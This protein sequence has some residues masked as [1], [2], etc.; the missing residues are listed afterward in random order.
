MVVI[1]AFALIVWL[2]WPNKPA[3]STVLSVAPVPASVPATSPGAIARDKLKAKAPKMPRRPPDKAKAL[4]AYKSAVE[5]GS[6]SPGAE[7]LRADSDDFFEFNLEQAKERAA[8]E[9]ITLD[10]LR[11]LT[12][13]GILA[14]RLRQWGDVELALGRELPEEVRNKGEDV[15]FT[16]SSEMKETIRSLVDRGATLAERNEAI[17]SIEQRFL[18]EF[19]ST[20]GLSPEQLDKLL[21]QPYSDQ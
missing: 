8:Q 14:M 4:A 9:R 18:S 19:L 10:E 13:I 3:P 6:T 1:G 7:A 15:I 5:K 21:A 17:E 12:Y 2:L 16:H 11:E 20:T